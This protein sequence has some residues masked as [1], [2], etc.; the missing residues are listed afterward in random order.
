MENQVIA[1]AAVADRVI[2]R[3]QEAA[4]DVRPEKDPRFE[5]MT[6]VE[7]ASFV[8]GLTNALG[9]LRDSE[10]V[11]GVMNT[12]QNKYASLLQTMIV[13]HRTDQ[14]PIAG[15]ETLEA[16]FD[17][18]DWLGWLGT[19]WEMVK[20]AKKFD[21]RPPVEGVQQV[22]Q[23]K[24][25]AR[26][27]VFGD[28]GTG[29]YGAPH[30]AEN[31]AK[32]TGPVNVV[33]HLG[34]V[35][36]SGKADEFKTR[37]TALWPKRDGALNR[38]VNG[39]HEMYCGGQPYIEAISSTTFKQARSC[40]AYESDHWIIVGLDTAYDDHDLASAQAGWLGRI[41][42]AKDA[43]QKVVLFSH[44]QPFSLMSG[45]GPKLVDKLKP[46]LEGQK[47]FAWYWGHEH[48]CVIYDRHPQWK[49]YGR[50]IGHA[51]MPEFR[52]KPMGATVPTR[53]FRRFDGK[54]ENG[55]TVPASWILDGPNPFIKGEETNFTPHG[56][57]M[58]RFEA[59]ALYETVYDADG[60]IARDENAL[61]GTS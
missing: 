51:G 38:A 11:R 29:L 34:D 42:A 3:F 57:V 49:L 17:T 2:N 55:I 61:K 36:Y 45:Q 52:P 58:L 56:Y 27:A 33:L 9:A 32:D 26:M 47:I 6:D 37:F 20:G 14:Q 10:K 54:V 15:L 44:H 30:I 18:H 19:F 50:C 25:G 28:W 5:G 41:V 16:K 39:N 8:A 59:D 60:S 12:P 13:E 46:L 43:Q 48:E 4:P 24:D 40:F 21:W 31:I 53:Q 1:T 35:Y 7:R 22:D 23:F